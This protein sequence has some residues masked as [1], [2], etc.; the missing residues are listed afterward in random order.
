MAY[1]NMLPRPTH[2]RRALRE[3]RARINA[4]SASRAIGP[5]KC[6]L[7]PTPMQRRV[8]EITAR[9]LLYGGAAG[10]GKTMALAF[11]AT[12][13]IDASH[14]RA[15]LMAQTDKQL[16]HSGGM[17]EALHSI[18]PTV[19]INRGTRQMRFPSG[20][21][22]EFATLPDST[23][24]ERQGI[25][26][27]QYHFIGIDEAGNIMPAQLE[28]MPRSQRRRI[29]DAVP[30]MY[31]LAANPGGVA[32]DWLRSRFVENRSGDYPENVFLHA[33]QKDNPHIDM[34]DYASSF[35]LMDPYTRMQF[36]EGLWDDPADGVFF[37]ADMLRSYDILPPPLRAVRAWDLA[38]TAR[39]DADF[40]AGALVVECWDEGADRT[41]YF[42]HAIEREQ[43][44]AGDVER[45]ILETAALDG[46]RVDVAIEQEQ[47]AGGKLFIGRLRDG[48]PSGVS[49][50][51]MRPS[52]SKEERARITAGLLQD[53]RLFVNAGMPQGKRR[54]LEGE[55]RRF[56]SAGAA[57]DDI[58]DALTYALIYLT[59]T[60]GGID[61]W[62]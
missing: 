13:H 2:S 35:R 28:W 36:V 33:Q 46:A 7:T 60:G 49:V 4:R 12:R 61:V 31:R 58:V 54:A 55:L 19:P 25:R 50:R 20:A 24:H 42:V 47:G 51:G 6:A 14:Y 1:A 39:A 27:S 34:D 29:G 56:G 52:G 23:A 22:I 32:H 53:G 21:L 26:G 38:A 16:S 57:H 5:L 48:A 45:L 62:A 43:M 41:A 30:T 44:S 9:N 3:S 18:Y 17:Y 59:S 40:T 11:C 8:S 15:L 10:A 37:R